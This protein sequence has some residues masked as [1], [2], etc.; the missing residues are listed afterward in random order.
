MSDG[1]N[2]TLTAKPAGTFLSMGRWMEPRVTYVQQN[3]D[4]T[5]G[6]DSGDRG[7]SQKALPRGN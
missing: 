5:L 6:I 4:L 2:R 7:I 3:S 1:I